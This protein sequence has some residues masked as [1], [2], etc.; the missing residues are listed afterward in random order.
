[1]NARDDQPP[2]HGEGL[3][4]PGRESGVPPRRRPADVLRPDFGLPK[5]WWTEPWSIWCDWR[6]HNRLLDVWIEQVRYYQN[7]LLFSTSE[8][9]E[10]TDRFLDVVDMR[11]FLYPDHSAEYH[12]AAGRMCAAVTG[13]FS[14]EHV[15]HD[16]DT[17]Y[18]EH[19][20]THH[21]DT[22]HDDDDAALVAGLEHDL[23]RAANWA[24]GSGGYYVDRHM[25]R[26]PSAWQAADS[27]VAALEVTRPLYQRLLPAPR[28]R[29]WSVGAD[30]TIAW[31]RTVSHVHE[32]DYFRVPDPSDPMGIFTHLWFRYEDYLT[33]SD[34]TEYEH[35][36]YQPGPDTDPLTMDY[37]P[38]NGPL[39]D[40][41]IPD[42]EPWM[43]TAYDRVTEHMDR[44]YAPAPP[45]E[46]PSAPPS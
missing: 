18:D 27:L 10:L 11:A 34:R 37:F 19:L 16:H 24:A 5:T 23:E 13:R 1:M 36:P 25:E 21:D 46:Q 41:T 28:N 2:A 8:E 32:E 26:R 17:A 33:P 40:F 22:D 15:I 45:T 20:D 38:I 14:P 3:P 29:R 44:R 9:S 12:T 7:N 6:R 42:A 35:S 30:L 39:A 43:V 4:E 31:V